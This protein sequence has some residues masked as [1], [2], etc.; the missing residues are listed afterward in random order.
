MKKSDKPRP[1]TAAISTVAAGARKEKAM[2]MY[3]FG[4]DKECDDERD[5]ALKKPAAAGSARPA[6]RAR[7][8]REE[9]VER[10]FDVTMGVSRH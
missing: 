6:R 1:R 7:R 4:T 10:K 5:N 8:A 9:K 3:C 2:R